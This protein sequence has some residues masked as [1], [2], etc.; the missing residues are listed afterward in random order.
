MQS[1]DDINDAF[2]L[3]FVHD[4]HPL[5]QVYVFGRCYRQIRENSAWR[6]I[7]DLDR[8]LNAAIPLMVD[9]ESRSYTVVCEFL[10]LRAK[11]RE[12]DARLAR[13]E[14]AAN[15]KD[16]QMPVE[17]AVRAAI[18]DAGLPKFTFPEHEMVPTTAWVLANEFGNVLTRF[19][20]LQPKTPGA[21][22]IAFFDSQA[23]AEGVHDAMGLRGTVRPQL[24]NRRTLEPVE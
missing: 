6:R 11:E 5:L 3:G 16:V 18:E 12:T 7:R 8:S 24:V 10:R 4:V 1:D 9:G 13:I 14:A 21:Y 22:E 2:I 17:E 20:G 15:T 19:F 23:E